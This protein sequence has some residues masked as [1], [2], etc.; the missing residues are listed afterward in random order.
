MPH[1]A[2]QLD[3]VMSNLPILPMSE[4][5]PVGLTCACAEDKPGVLADITRILADPAD[6]DQTRC[7]ATR[8]GRGEGETDIIVRR[9]P[10]RK[11]P[12]RCDREDRGA[13]RPAL[14]RSSA[15]ARK[16][17]QYV[18]PDSLPSFRWRWPSGGGRRFAN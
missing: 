3:A 11:A 2:F 7:R 15:S 12:R 13:P 6:L 18:A 4:T 5:R 8:A 9:P 10:A 16:S 14:G 1:L 17:W